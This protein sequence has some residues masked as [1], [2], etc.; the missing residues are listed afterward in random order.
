MGKKGHIG[1]IWTYM[2]NYGH[3]LQFMVKYGKKFSNMVKNDMS[4]FMV[5]YVNTCLYIDI[6]SSKDFKYVQS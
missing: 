3:V 1:L 6:Y 2:V 5:M 4:S